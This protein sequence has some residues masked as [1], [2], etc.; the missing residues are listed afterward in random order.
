M[1]NSKTECCERCLYT[2]FKHLP[3]QVALKLSLV[4]LVSQN[5]MIENLSIVDLT[6]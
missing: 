2:Q 1:G 3:P 4:G 6:Q 5:N